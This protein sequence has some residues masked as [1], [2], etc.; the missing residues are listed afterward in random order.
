M[1][2]VTMI[3]AGLLTF[4]MRL[5]FIWLFGRLDLPGWLMRALS[6]VPV[7]VF[8]AIIFPEVLAPSGVLGLTLSNP[9]LPAALAAVWVAWKTRNVV[10]VVAVGMGVLWL[11]TYWRG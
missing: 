8:C 5:S 6:Y 9:R 1:I 10:W 11:L 3:A 2:W 7:A 4:L